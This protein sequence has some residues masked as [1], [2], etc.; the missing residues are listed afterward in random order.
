MTIQ[1]PALFSLY[2]QVL[3]LIVKKKGDYN[4]TRPLPILWLVGSGNVAGC[5]SDRSVLLILIL[6][7]QGPT[8]VGFFFLSPVIPLF[9]LPLSLGV[10]EGWPDIYRNIVLKGR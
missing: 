9:F 2:M 7:W 6:I 3:L 10:G 1:R 4:L 8:V 5:L